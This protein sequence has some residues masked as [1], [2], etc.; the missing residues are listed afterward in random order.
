[1]DNN[2]KILDV[3]KS[4][5]EFKEYIKIEDF[6]FGIIP[7]NLSISTMNLTCELGITFNRFNIYNYII[8]ETDNIISIKSS[9]GIKCLNNLKKNFKSITKNSKKNFYNNTTVIVNVS[10][11]KFV[12]V[13]LFHNGSIQ[14]SGCKELSDANIVLNKL[15][16]KLSEIVVIDN[17]GEI[18]EIK[19][20]NN[21]DLFFVKDF[22]ID[23]IN[24]N[25]TVRYSINKERLY[26]ILVEENIICILANSHACVNIKYKI[27]ENNYVSIFV[28]QT[29]NI[30]ITG[31]KNAEDIKKT[32]TFIVK[33][34]NKYK[35]SVIKINILEDN[36]II[37]LLSN[38]NINL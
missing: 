9:Y 11:N 2:I 7:E 35:A 33:L 14:I 6:N 28:F 10:D 29:G 31:A 3:I 13:K 37:T 25:F 30:L 36:D 12:N 19:F 38:Y 16:S 15:K 1:M 20:I 22:K 24:S 23:L 4:S 27:S 32:Y 8:L 21:I 34:L 17:N 26:N 5:C 18:M